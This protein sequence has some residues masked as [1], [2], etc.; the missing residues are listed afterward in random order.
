LFLMGNS[1][2]GVFSSMGV[3]KNDILAQWKSNTMK[4]QF[5]KELAF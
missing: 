5:H 4:N 1:K 3:M 2:R